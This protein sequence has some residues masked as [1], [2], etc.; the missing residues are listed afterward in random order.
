ML[1]YPELKALAFTNLLWFVP[2]LFK[3]EAEKPP[4]CNNFLLIFQIM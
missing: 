4:P 1:R 2:K 3:M